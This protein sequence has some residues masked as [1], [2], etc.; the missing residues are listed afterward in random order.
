M[1][2]ESDQIPFDDVVAKMLSK[3]MSPVTISAVLDCDL[4]YVN[5]FIVNPD[6]SIPQSEDEIGIMAL[7]LAK[8]AYEE[9]NRILDEGTP[10]MKIRLITSIQPHYLRAMNNQAPKAFDDLREEMRKLLS[11]VGTDS[12]EPGSIY[13]PD[14][15]ED[16][17]A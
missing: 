7:Q 9:A 3:G 5:S 13:S 6:R 17:E 14:V 12:S 4:A 11:D 1:T 15:T 8:R 10:A 2:T 16:V